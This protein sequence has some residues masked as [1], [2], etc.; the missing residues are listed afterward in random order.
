MKTEPDRIFE[1]FS[2][3]GN[4]RIRYG[5]KGTCGLA[6][7]EDVR[8]SSHVSGQKNFDRRKTFVVSKERK[9]NVVSNDINILTIS[10]RA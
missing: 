10:L 4:V 9:F 3:N 6:V 5:E 8:K 2:H 1:K 7:M